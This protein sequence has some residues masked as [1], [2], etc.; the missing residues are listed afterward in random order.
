VP[1]VYYGGW[2]VLSQVE[3]HLDPGMYILAGGGISLSGSSS[4][5]AI[6]SATG[7]T[8]RIT[9]FSTDGPGCPQISVQCQGAI[10]FTANQAFQ[11]K[12][13][14]TASCTAILNA[15][16]PNICPWRGILLWQDGGASNATATVKLG[17]QASTIMSGTIYAP[18]AEV[19][20]NG[21]TST[22]G[23]SGSPSASCLSIQIIAYRW[24]IDGGALVDMPY[25]PAELYQLDLR[26]LV[27]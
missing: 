14:N 16:G 22:T 17:G 25:D 11:A 12:A 8:A 27:H 4:I 20:I 21:G 9:I 24:K 5:E 23:C 26:G 3:V 2:K 10:T 15:G 13:T 18:L 6:D 7:G 1:G 19:D